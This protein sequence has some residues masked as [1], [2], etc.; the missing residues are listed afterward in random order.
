MSVELEVVPP[1]PSYFS[2]SLTQKINS[3][4]LT[5][6]YSVLAAY[7]FYWFTSFLPRKITIYRSK[8]ILSKQVNRLLYELFVLIHQIFYVFEIDKRIE[9]IEE[10]D[11][12]HIDGDISRSLK[13]VYETGV[14]WRR[15]WKRGKK[16]TGL[17]WMEFV[18][19]E[20]IKKKLSEIPNYI[21]KIRASSPNFDADEVFAETLASIE[22]NKI[23]EW[24]S[25]E[26][27]NKMFLYTGSSTELFNLINDYKRLLS[28]GY[29]K[30]FRNSYNTI[31]FY[32]KKE[33]ED[34]PKKR[35]RLLLSFAP[36]PGLLKL[37]NPCIIYNPDYVDA[38]AV[39]S[40]LNKVPPGSR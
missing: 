40:E 22:T 4:L 2:D 31:R 30:M 10:K 6:S 15:F 37:L 5:L 29:Q 39:I 3:S 21:G 20:G 13:G 33:I 19:P 27:K 35:E 34:I 26:E 12:L 32:T 38:R 14:H 1:I 25:S 24:Y 18:Y 28:L 7:V 17:A 11:L 36:Q 9:E 16:F 8:K 23:I